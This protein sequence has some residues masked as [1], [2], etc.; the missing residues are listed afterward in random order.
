MSDTDQL[1]GLEERLSPEEQA[2]LRDAKRATRELFR[3]LQ[4]TVPRPE[5]GES[6]EALSTLHRTLALALDSIET[7]ALA[8]AIDRRERAET[9]ES[10]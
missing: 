3:A 6:S 2:L 10:K 9:S 4:G 1:R 5:K 8:V 7:G